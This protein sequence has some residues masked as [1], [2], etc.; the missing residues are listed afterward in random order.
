MKYA[1]SVIAFLIALGASAKADEG[2]TPSIARAMIDAAEKS[3][4]A[5]E[6]AAVTQAAKKVFPDF[7]EEIDA[8]AK[9]KI[10][11]LT[12]PEAPAEAAPE[13]KIAPALGAWEGKLG[14]SAA[15]AK[16][17]SE[18]TAIGVF[19]DARREAER[20]AHN[21]R[22][23]ADFGRSNGAQNLKRWGSLYQFDYKFNDRTYAFARVS[24]DE[25]A[26]SGYDYRL[27]GGGGVGHFLAK[28]DRVTWKL[29]AGPGYQYSPVDDTRAIEKELA[30]YAGTQL[31]W[32]IRPGLT[33]EQDF[34]AVW[35]DPTT[36]LV[37]LTGLSASLTD[38]LAAGVGYEWRHE[39]DPPLGR[40]KTDT[41]LRANINYGF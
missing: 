6:V 1:A 26:F 21:V 38:S 18:N 20:T 9:P 17:N 27:F 28:S 11:A 19:L 39:T 29:E 32:V 4:D 12:P 22:G 33:F 24:Y 14:A 25:D 30:I 2:A 16:G 15:V 3:G 34:S 7:A 31:D 5:G 23:Y 35:T 37:S 10:A 13:K 8:Y 41:L 36:T 40:K